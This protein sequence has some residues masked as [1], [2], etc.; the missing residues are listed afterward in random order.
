MIS[1]VLQYNDQFTEKVLSLLH[2]CYLEVHTLHC[3]CEPTITMVSIVT[4][5]IEHLRYN[6]KSSSAD[7]Q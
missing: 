4:N 2:G 5:K 3:E 6:R 1:N 7:K